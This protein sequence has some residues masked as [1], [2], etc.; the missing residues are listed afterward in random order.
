LR[1][2]AQWWCGWVGHAITVHKAV[3]KEG[4]FPSG[5]GLKTRPMMPGAVHARLA[6]PT[7]V[8]AQ[9]QANDRAKWHLAPHAGGPWPDTTP[10]GRSPGRCHD[11][12]WS[13]EMP[14]NC[15]H[16]TPMPPA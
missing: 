4:R 5:D 10:T 7:A 3:S 8:V 12:G 14:E 6:P 11:R 15:R 2:A 9:A 1:T 16:L 13:A